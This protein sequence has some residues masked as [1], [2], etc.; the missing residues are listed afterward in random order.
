MVIQAIN[1]ISLCTRNGWCVHISNINIIVTEYNAY[2]YNYVA[3]V[4]TLYMKRKAF[5]IFEKLAVLLCAADI[6]GPDD[7][8][9]YT[10]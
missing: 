3:P 1:E 6:C 4:N 7:D 8:H 5:Y 2:C 9:R 10:T